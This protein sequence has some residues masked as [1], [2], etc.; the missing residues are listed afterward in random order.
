VS[1]TLIFF[2][3]TFDSVDPGL[4][5]FFLQVLSFSL[6]IIS[7]CNEFCHSFGNIRKKLDNI[8]I[9]QEIK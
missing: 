5:L 8:L 1:G 2:F 4:V 7:D 3:D 9:A 6:L